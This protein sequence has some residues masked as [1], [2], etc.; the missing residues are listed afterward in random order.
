MRSLIYTETTFIISDEMQHKKG[1]T[2]FVLRTCTKARSINYH[3]S[4]LQEF[5]LSPRHERD[6]G[7]W[8]S[9]G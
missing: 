4:S 3:S 2:Y 1:D 6:L 8:L 5:N 7:K 9:K